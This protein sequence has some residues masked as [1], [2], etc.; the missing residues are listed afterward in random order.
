MLLIFF[1][2]LGETSL[3]WIMAKTKARICVCVC[4]A[5]TPSA[6]LISLHVGSVQ[7]LVLTQKI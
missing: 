6:Y 4:A 3:C 2:N 5:F 7:S 1:S